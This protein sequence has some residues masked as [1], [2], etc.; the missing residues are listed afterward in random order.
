MNFTDV[1]VLMLI[2]SHPGKNIY[3]LHKLAEIEM[4]RWDWSY[5]KIQKA[6]QRLKKEK[7]VSGRIKVDGGRACQELWATV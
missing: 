5:G 2:R 6:V 3:Q 1:Q 7:K 4:P